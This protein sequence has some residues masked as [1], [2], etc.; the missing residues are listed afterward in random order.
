MRKQTAWFSIFGQ[1]E[2][3]VASEMVKEGKISRIEPADIPESALWSTDL[4]GNKVRAKFAVIVP[5]PHQ[6]EFHNRILDL[7]A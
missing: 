2:E 7:R 3:V 5:V 1:I 4:L 6:R